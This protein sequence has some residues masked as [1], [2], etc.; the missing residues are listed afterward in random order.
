MKLAL[1]A[2][3]A[4][5]HVEARRHGVVTASNMYSKKKC[6]GVIAAGAREHVECMRM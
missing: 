1:F 2:N 6:L 4:C 3:L 5:M